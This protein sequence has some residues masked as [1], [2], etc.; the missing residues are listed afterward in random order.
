MLCPC[1]NATVCVL[2]VG[3]G[4][5][6]VSR[7]QW[8]KVKGIYLYNDNSMPT[9]IPHHL[10]PVTTLHPLPSSPSPLSPPSLTSPFPHLSV[11][12]H[13][14]YT[15]LL[16][17]SGRK[18]TPIPTNTSP[19]REVTFSNYQWENISQTEVKICS[20]RT[21]TLYHIALQTCGLEVLKIWEN[22][23]WIGYL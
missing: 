2:G 8:D 18:K 11:V 17:S 9:L 16:T 15:S 10:Y 6:G 20:D 21:S 3:G 23:L 1:M 7:G 4:G 19:I 5:V 22:V 14:V 12:H 13:I